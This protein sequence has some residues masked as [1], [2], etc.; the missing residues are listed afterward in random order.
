MHLQKQ[1]F[2]LKEVQPPVSRHGR[3]VCKDDWNRILCLQGMKHTRHR[4]LGGGY[5]PI[6]NRSETNF[7]A[8]KVQS[9]GEATRRRRR[10]SDNCSD[11]IIDI[12]RFTTR[13][14]HFLSLFFVTSRSLDD[15]ETKQRSN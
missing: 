8:N 14:L 4:A 1:K 9:L 7:S 13:A 11:N 2:T 15:F 3:S 10:C 6:A 5:E 12:T